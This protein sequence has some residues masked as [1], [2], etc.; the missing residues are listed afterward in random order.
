MAHSTSTE[1]RLSNARSDGWRLGALALLAVWIMAPVTLPVPVLRELVGERFA[2]SEFATSLFM[3]V[4][5]IGAL[6]MAPLAGA[7]SD[8]WGRKRS[9]LVVALAVD[10][11]C[12]FGLAAPVPF[13]GFLAIRFVEGCAHITALSVLLMLASRALPAE[14]RGRAMGAVGGSMM[15]G[16]ALGAPLGGLLGQSSTLL[17]LYVG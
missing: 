6:L 2:V 15:I 4:N 10:A 1:K 9:L 12:F 16:V 5:M 13:W 11:G 14:H 17:P 7:F 3:S 8:R